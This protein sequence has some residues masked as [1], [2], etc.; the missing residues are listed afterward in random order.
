MNKSSALLKVVIRTLE[1]QTVKSVGTYGVGF[2]EVPVRAFV[3]RTKQLESETHF[4]L[5]R[6]KPFSHTQVGSGQQLV[7]FL[8]G[9]GLH[10][11]HVV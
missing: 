6:M 5:R 8:P 2:V 11:A 9:S 4:P 1:V 7:T 3:V 10:E